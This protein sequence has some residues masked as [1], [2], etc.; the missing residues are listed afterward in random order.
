MTVR[1]LG[2]ERAYVGSAFFVIIGLISAIGTALVYGV[3]GYLVI[4]N[5]FTI[6]T[7]VA[8]G[9][10]LGQMYGAL[11][12]LVNA[13]VDFATSVVSFERVFEV[14]DLPEG[15]PEKTDALVLGKT[16]G[17]LAFEGVSFQYDIAENQLSDVRR[18][19]QMDN[20]TAVLSG[21]PGD[22]RSKTRP[23]VETES[24]ETQVHSHHLHCPA[25]AP[26]GPGGTFR[27]G[28]DDHN[29]PD[30]APL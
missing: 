16:R 20:V 4:Q 30:P 15:I 2:I 25:R 14:I 21:T 3:G 1:D 17:E 18:Y 27:G 12:N 24:E 26:G 9:S 6:G 29:L 19:G 10:Y 22:G 13:P 8:F 5:A 28:E 7:I 11:Q 23:A